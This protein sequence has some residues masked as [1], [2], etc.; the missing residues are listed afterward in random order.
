MVN[1]SFYANLLCTTL[2]LVA[3]LGCIFV[4]YLFLKLRHPKRTHEI[5]Q[6]CLFVAIYLLLFA[7]PVVSIK[8]VELFGC[9]DIE[10]TYYLRADYSLECYTTEWTAMAVYA[11]VFLVTYVVGFPLFVGARLWWYRH[12][13]RARAQGPDQ[14]CKLAPKGLLL[15][16]LLDDYVLRLPCYMWE[17]VEMGRKLC[18]SV[19]GNFWSDKSV[20]SIGTALII[21]LVFQLLHTRLHPFK[22]AA[23]NRLQQICLSVLNAVYIAGLLLQTQTTSATDQ[24]DL[25]VLLVLLLVAAVVAV[26]AAVVL[27]IQE[28]LRAMTRTRRLAAVLRRLPQ[29]DPPDDT[30]GFY[31]IQIPVQES[32][33][34]DAFEPK[35]P[36]A[37]AHLTSEAKLVVVRLL[38]KANEERLANFF[39]KLGTDPTIPLQQAKSPS[40]V[41]GQGLVC[42]KSSKKTEESILAKAVRP[43]IL[44]N[45]PK[46]GIEHIRDTFRFKCVVFSFRDAVEF[47]FAMH[48]DRSLCPN[49]GLSPQ[50]VAKLD[51]AKL[52]APKEWGWRF[53]AF[54]FVMPNHQIVECYIVFSEMEHAKKN[55]DPTAT[56]CAELSNHEIFERW[57]VVDTAKLRGDRRAEFERDREESNRRYDHAFAVVLSHTSAVELEEFWRLFSTDGA[58]G[59]GDV[60]GATGVTQQFSLGPATVEEGIAQAMGIRKK[61][62]Q[63][64]EENLVVR[65]WSKSA[66]GGGG[67]ELGELFEH[68]ES[69]FEGKNPLALAGESNEPMRPS[70]VA[71]WGMAKLI[72]FLTYYLHCIACL[73]YPI[74]KEGWY[75]EALV[76]YPVLQRIS[77]YLVS[78][79]AVIHLTV[80]ASGLDTVWPT[81]NA[82]ARVQS[83]MLLLGAC[84]VASIF[85]N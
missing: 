55:D 14:V 16:F 5:K 58:A 31:D 27:E 29:Q 25:G 84:I 39:H 82:E 85:G 57:R 4:S 33:M 11:S 13:L 32:N 59:G 81:T 24:H 6:T 15:G 37:L 54:D 64:A 30:K 69:T 70:H 66:M 77:P 50:N 34:G 19:V 10:G 9:H 1:L 46:F 61:R 44:A 7:Y 72:M 75:Q 73:W 40:Y 41:T 36:A 76:E 28:L 49:S 35:S 51:V 26:S 48:S 65:G 43:V 8:V 23:C 3:L 63:L 18:L 2:L 83:I 21:S 74:S 22:S 47:V 62:S 56:V 20:M 53:L 17:T 78:V 42:A 52:K 71:L 79:Q 67:V 68:P 38:T 12:E 60:E 45:N 80:G